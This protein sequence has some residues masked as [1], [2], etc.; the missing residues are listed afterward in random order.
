MIHARKLLSLIERKRRLFVK[1][2][3]CTRRVNHDTKILHV[4][5][6]RTVS[7]P[8]QRADGRRVVTSRS[9]ASKLHFYF[10]I[11]SMSVASATQ[12]KCMKENIHPLFPKRFL[13]AYRK[14]CKSEETR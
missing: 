14:Y 11:R 1:R 6:L 2:L 4:F 8:A 3:K 9:N 10:P 7:P 5:F 12:V 13:I